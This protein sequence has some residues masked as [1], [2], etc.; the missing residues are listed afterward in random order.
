MFD[1][2]WMKKTSQDSTLD[3]F[4]FLSKN[5]FSK[6]WAVNSVCGLSAGFYSICWSLSSKGEG[7]N[8]CLLAEIGTQIDWL[9][10]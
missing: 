7:V 8:L 10:L 4:W 9:T 6:I 1:E 5:F 3:F 2:Q